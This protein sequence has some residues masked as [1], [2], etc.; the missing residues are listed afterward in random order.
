MIRICCAF[1][2]TVPETFK[3]ATIKWRKGMG[4]WKL[5]TKTVL[6]INSLLQQRILMLTHGSKKKQIH[7]KPTSFEKIGKDIMTFPRCMSIGVWSCFSFTGESYNLIFNCVFR[8]VRMNKAVIVKINIKHCARCL[9][10]IRRTQSVFIFFM[11]S[12]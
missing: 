11:Y 5:K 2:V 4:T 8:K 1:P 7:Q 3:V 12:L 6:K 9:A 10:S